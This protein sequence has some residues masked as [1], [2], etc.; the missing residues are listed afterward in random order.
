MLA[1][2][3]SALGAG[4]ILTSLALCA[5]YRA[6]VLSEANRTLHEVSH[7]H[8]GAG[9]SHVFHGRFGTPTLELEPSLLVDVCHYFG[10]AG[11][12]SDHHT[13]SYHMLGVTAGAGSEEI[14]HV[15]IWSPRQ[16]RFVHFGNWGA[17]K[18]AEVHCHFRLEP[19]SCI[20]PNSTGGT[21]HG[22]ER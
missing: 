11:E 7:G 6:C 17:S 2:A 15:F 10:W 20:G 19:N 8:H 1:L 14:D 3:A 9:V 16:R 13:P 22:L 18:C 21:C 4:T 12:P 5:S